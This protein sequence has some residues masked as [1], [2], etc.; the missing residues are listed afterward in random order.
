MAGGEREAEDGRRMSERLGRQLTRREFDAVIRRAA[1]LAT[2]DPESPETGLTEAELYRIAREVGLREEH[3]R[4]ALADVRRGEGEEGLLVR[5]FGPSA[6]GASRVVPGTPESLS[7]QIDDFLVASQLLQ[8]VRRGENVLHYRPAVDWA[9]EVARTASFVSRKYYIASAR[10][11]EIVLDP[12]DEGRTVVDFRIDPGNRGEDLGVALLGGMMCGAAAGAVSWWALTGAVAA[13]VALAVGGA[14]GVGVAGTIVYATAAS[15]RRK[16][17][18]ARSEVE[19]VLDALERGAS[20]DPPPSSWRRWVKRQ[21]HGMARDLVGD[22]D[23]SGRGRDGER[24][25][26]GDGHT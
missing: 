1:E 15:H 20:L 11:V 22:K 3:V 18:E 5:I 9:S 7:V 24:A 21:F 13:A 2:S 17:D 23:T 4:R 10:S 26:A 6:V 12:L 25:P 8:A 16:V 19:G 14:L